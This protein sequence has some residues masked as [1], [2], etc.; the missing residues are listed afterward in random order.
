MLFSPPLLA[1]GNFNFLRRQISVLRGKY[2]NMKMSWNV[3]NYFSHLLPR[4]APH[5]M[6]GYSDVLKLKF[7]YFIFGILPSNFHTIK[8]FTPML[9]SMIHLFVIR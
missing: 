2:K 5:S 9:Q 4:P 1:D 8:F 6:G 7:E 3:R